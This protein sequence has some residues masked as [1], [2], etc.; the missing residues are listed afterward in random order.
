MSSDVVS[1]DL[2]TVE[3]HAQPSALRDAHAEVVTFLLQHWSEPDKEL[4][5][6]FADEQEALHKDL[7]LSELDA[8]VARQTRLTALHLADKCCVTDGKLSLSAS[9]HATLKGL[10][11]CQAA[12]ALKEQADREK[13]P[14][15]AREAWMQV[16]RCLCF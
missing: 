13:K 9:L 11:K 15:A 3:M 8:K 16:R 2:V 5:R 12:A 4:F 1:P 7:P 10:R 14:D 6:K